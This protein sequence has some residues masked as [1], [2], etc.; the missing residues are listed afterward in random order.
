MN[1]TVRR[2][3]IVLAWIAAPLAAQ[4][5]MRRHWSGT[6]D[7]PGGQLKMDVDLDKTASGWIGSVSIPAQGV[8]GLPP[9][10]ISFSDGK[11]SFRLKGV[12]GDPAFTGTLSA[13]GKLLEG[14]FA[15]G[16]RSR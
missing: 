12:P 9:D 7:T 13:D 15:Q 6:L 8:N 1:N 5:D 10:A 16:R 11:G 3:A 14:T 2:A 4:N